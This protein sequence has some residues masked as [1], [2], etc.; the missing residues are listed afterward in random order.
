MFFLLCWNAVQ[1]LY[2]SALLLVC[3]LVTELVIVCARALVVLVVLV[4]DGGQLE[5]FKHVAR[6]LGKQQVGGL[7]EP[8][9]GF[10]C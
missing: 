3:C 8:E 5:V 1:F 10:A 4:G 7:K 6:G 2:F 9:I